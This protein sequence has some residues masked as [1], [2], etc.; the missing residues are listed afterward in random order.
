MRMFKKR[1]LFVAV[2]SV[3]FTLSY[4][5]SAQT[6]REVVA[7]TVATNPD[8]RVA[9][10]LRNASN[11]GVAQARAGYFPTVDVNT[12]YGKERA[13]NVNTT[14]TSTTLWR[15]DMGFAARQKIFDGFATKSEVERNR[16]KTNAD[17]YKVWGTA[18]DKA[19]SAVQSYLDILRNQELVGIAEKNLDVHEHTL[20]IIRRLTEQGLGREADMDQTSGRVDLA[21]AN[22][23]AARNALEDSKVTFQKVTGLVPHDLQPAPDVEMDDIPSSEAAAVE[24][25]IKNH[26]L[27]KSSVA[28]IS[29]ARGQY[30][31]AK[32][33]FYPMIDFVFTGYHNKNQ[34][35]V[36]GPNDDYL[37]MLQLNYNILAGGKDIGRVRETAYEVQRSIEIRNRTE[38]EVVEAM[39]LSWTAYRNATERMPSLRAHKSSS[40]QTTVAYGK[41]FQL[42]KRTILDVLDSQNEYF[43][44]SQDLVNE[45]YALIFAKYRIEHDMG[46]LVE[47]MHVPLPVEASIPYCLKHMC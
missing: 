29:E 25:A 6:L 24:L 43:T 42:G 20:G 11:E 22:L 8:I 21:R 44:A 10:K 27:L 13:D 46:K 40:D 34:G 28:D 32:A 47:E 19:L 23:I 7:N 5:A 18:E 30:V 1:I 3:L 37:A 4:H 41:Q 12:G 38:R 31:S 39:K 17:A 33:K 45:R 16:A 2:T 26:P 14:F 9:A 15:T 35:G 36:A